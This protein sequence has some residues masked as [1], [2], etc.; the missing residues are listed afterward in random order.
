MNRLTRRLPLR[1]LAAGVVLAGITTLAGCAAGPDFKRPAPPTVD[2]YT[3]T[4][5]PAVVGRAADAQRLAP[6]TDLPAQWWQLFH[7]PELDARV[8]QALAANP[9]LATAQAALRQAQEVLAAGGS[10]RFPGVTADV[11]TSRGRT[12]PPLSSP[13]ASNADEYRLHTA[14][15]ETSWSPD[16]FGGTRRQLEALRAQVDV[17]RY[18]LA[19]AQLSLTANVVVATINQASLGAQI[20]ATRDIIASQQHALASVRR[21]LAL[22]QLAPADVAA[23]EAALAQS[24]ATLPPLEKQLHQQDDA[25]AALLG[26]APAQAPSASI[27]LADLHLPATLPV[28]LPAELIAHRPDVQAAEAQWHAAN[29]QIGVAVANRLPKL[30]I[31]ASLGSSAT[32]WR[33]LL[34]RGGGFWSLAGDLAQ[35][36][37]DAGNLRHQQRAA[38][39]ARDAA[40][41]QYRGAVIGAL[42]SVADA[43]YALEGD[44][45]T[46]AAAREAEQ[47]AHRSLV[48]SQHAQAWGDTSELAVLQARQA[49]QQARIAAVQATAARYS[50]TAALFQSLGGSWWH[51]PVAATHEATTMPPATPRGTPHD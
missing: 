3:A 40:A 15:L 7:A 19:A 26:T 27:T 33:D 16:L 23:Q 13:L 44:A 10:A 18:Q 37:F 2:R 48:I 34:R 39:A 30:S 29:A 14:Q 25:L 32:N 42:Q 38:V 47:A 28:S 11:N 46:L 17:A 5:Q 9:S 22:G 45:D 49:W 41:A 4:A 24:R 1:T 12:S 20:A 43:L 8:K 31:T 51:A 35:P 21:Q 36:V 50:D 6:G